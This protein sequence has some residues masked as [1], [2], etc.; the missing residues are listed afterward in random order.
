M[1]FQVATPSLARRCS[2]TKLLPLFN[3]VPRLRIELGT[4]GIS[5]RQQHLC[6]E[7]LTHLAAVGQAVEQL[8]LS[9]QQY[10]IDGYEGR[11]EV[12]VY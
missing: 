12:S 2:A 6:I 11:S 3:L 9:I 4:R 8:L 5:V 7:I 1:R 10:G